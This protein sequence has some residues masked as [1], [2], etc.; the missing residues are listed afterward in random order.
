M[1]LLVF[2]EQKLLPGHFNELFAND[3]RQRLLLYLKWVY[4][5]FGWGNQCVAEVQRNKDLLSRFHPQFPVEIIPAVA[6]TRKL[7]C[8]R[9]Q[10]PLF[11]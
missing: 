2:S 1:L 9:A 7:C 6:A 4:E 5:V 3:L 11:L 10:V 8:K